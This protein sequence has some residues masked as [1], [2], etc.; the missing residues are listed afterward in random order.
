MKEFDFGRE[1]KKEI[2]EMTPEK[3]DEYNKGL[4]AQLAAEQAE[5]DKNKR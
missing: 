4:D 5:M 1:L 2:S 3:L